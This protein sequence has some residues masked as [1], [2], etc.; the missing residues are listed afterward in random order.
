[1]HYS[2]HL[3]CTCVFVLQ[4]FRTSEG[5]RT[6]RIDRTKHKSKSPSTT[7]L[8]NA[9]RT[10]LHWSKACSALQSQ[11]NHFGFRC[12]LPERNLDQTHL[13]RPEIL[14]HFCRVC[15]HLLR[16]TEAAPPLHQVAFTGCQ[17]L[18]MAFKRA[19]TCGSSRTNVRC[20]YPSLVFDKAE[21]FR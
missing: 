17:R 3:S 16:G 5:L 21:H 15:A 19:V 10:S 18:S 7:S 8:I 12:H 6:V 14:C 4:H 20:I 2:M 11:F 13:T 9:Q 1:M